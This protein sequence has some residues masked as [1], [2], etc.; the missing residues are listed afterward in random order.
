MPT[1]IPEPIRI[2]MVLGKNLCSSCSS[3]VCGDTIEC[4][5]Y[6]LGGGAEREYACFDIGKRHACQE[7]VCVCVC[8]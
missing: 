7:C 3:V 8:L 6:V 4:T 5:I 1:H 2:G